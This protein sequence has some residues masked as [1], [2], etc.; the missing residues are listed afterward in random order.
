MITI[1]FPTDFSAT[2]NN[3]FLYALNLTKKL[4][5][6]LKVLSVK[7]HLKDY[8]DV[9]DEHI[10]EEKNKL[11]DI[12]KVHHLD[13]VDFTFQI[14]IGELIMKITEI[15]KNENVNYIVMGT[16]GE[17]SFGKKFF[18]SETLSVINNTTIPVL[19]VPDKVIYKEQ[20]NF[21]FATL[22]NDSEEKALDEMISITDR[23]NAN[24]DVVHVEVKSMTFDMRK[25]KQEWEIN[26]PKLNLTV[27]QKEDVEG[28]LLDY[29]KQNKV[30]VLGLV[31][32]DLNTFQRMFTTNHSKQLLTSADFALLILPLK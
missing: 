14:E 27:I 17:N 2:A 32:R 20:R 11:K 25:K 23:Y 18:G 30:D 13:D 26:H 5:A 15:V 6:N 1:L 19:A 3:A 10:E 21:S 9:K 7:T 31:H 29:C 24:L 16:N 12:A 28:A 4:N 8:L 22:F